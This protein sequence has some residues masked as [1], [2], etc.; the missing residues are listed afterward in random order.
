VIRAGYS[1]KTGEQFFHMMRNV[2]AQLPDDQLGTLVAY[3]A[4][5]GE[6]CSLSVQLAAIWGMSV[7]IDGGGR[8]RRQFVP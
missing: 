8:W 5:G 6:W 2:G 4:A 1:A 7:E 3:L